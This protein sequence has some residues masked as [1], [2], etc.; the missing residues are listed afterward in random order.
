MEK[1]KKEVNKKCYKFRLYP[2]KKQ[3][4]QLN[5]IRE[6]CKRMY[7]YLFWELS[8]PYEKIK[9]DIPFIGEL[10]LGIKEQLLEVSCNE[11]ESFARD[12]L[13]DYYKLIKPNRNYIQRQVKFFREVNPEMKK[14][15]FSVLQ[16]Q[17]W[18]LFGNLKALSG[19]KKRGHIVGRLKPKRF[20]EF[21]TFSYPNKTQFKLI[22]N[23]IGYSK[24]HL[25]WIGNIKIKLHR[26]IE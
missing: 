2:N 26:L 1:P 11:R 24:L 10:R 6:Q 20:R 16:Y 3:E 5:F 25:N 7:N 8:Q 14:V 19:S 23:K 21:N 9:E 15:L 22:D 18:K 17:N 4:E 13:N 12:I